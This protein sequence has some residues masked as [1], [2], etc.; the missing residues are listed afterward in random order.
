MNEF[1][2]VKVVLAQSI[3]LGRDKMKIMITGGA[4]YIGSHIAL[5]AL[6]RGDDVIIYDNLSNT[7][8]RNLD[9]LGSRGA[10]VVQGDVLDRTLLTDTMRRYRPDMIIHAAAMKDAVESEVIPF[11][12][13]KTNV[14]GTIMVLQ[15]MEDAGLSKLIFSSSSSVYGDGSYQ[16][17]ESS[18]LNPKSAYARSKVMAEELVADFA[19][20]GGTVITL[21][22][23][24]PV[25]SHPLI[26][27]HRSNSFM[28]NLTGAASGRNR[29]ITLFNNGENVR[30]FIHVQDLAEV[31]LHLDNLSGHHVFNVGT[32]KGHMIKDVVRLMGSVSN[33]DIP[34]SFCDQ[35]RDGDVKMSISNSMKIEQSVGWKASRSI[36]QMCRDAWEV[37][38]LRLSSER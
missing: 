14:D 5:Q 2:S 20:R 1:V 4:G 15:A 30:D 32:G 34:K 13:Y 17:L 12:Y 35:E 29:G 36:E 7:G 9:F 26:P 27:Q 10:T 11:Q 22:Y 24:N 3:V 33:R 21:R 18:A 19:Q 37:E 23:F 8:K 31:H 16:F 28:S 6:V 38:T 25:A